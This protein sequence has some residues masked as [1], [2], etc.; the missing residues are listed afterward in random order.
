VSVR[1]GI[2]FV[3]SAPSGT[4]KTTVCR[5]LVARDRGIEF[6]VSHTT[7]KRRPAEVDGRDYHFVTRP[8]FERLVA[9]GRFVEHA[10]YAGN[11]YGTSFDSLDAPLSDGRDLLLEVDVQGAL[12]LRTQRPDAR[13]V[14][15]LP[16]SLAE[17]ERRLRGRNT[18]APEVVERRLALVRK[19]LAA[20]HAFD[21]AVVNEDVERTVEALREIVAAER[22][23]DPAAVRAKHGRAAV[24]SRLAGVLPIPPQAGLA[25]LG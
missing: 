22:S 12:Q 4:G 14:F 3:V 9:A 8:E 21:Y 20:V 23:G 24:L 10:E 13:F 17:L 11:L 1:R 19:E 5:G 7:R 16:P 2:P 15:L 6:S 25:P 18:D